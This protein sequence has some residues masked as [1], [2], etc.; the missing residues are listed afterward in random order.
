[1][2]E[3]DEKQL[4]QQIKSEDFSNAYFIYGEESYLK[5]YYVGRLKSKLIGKNFEDF[6]LH[7][8]NGKKIG[9]SDILKDADLLPM[10]GGYNLVLVCDYPFD[11]SSA[12]CGVIKEYLKDVP[13]TTVLLFWYDTVEVDIKKNS[14]WKSIQSAFAKAGSSVCF[15]K[16]SENELVKMLVNGCKRRNAALSPENAKYLISFSGSDI[17]TLLNET[18]KLCAFVGNGEI[19]LDIINK[20]AVKS[21]QAKV[22][23]LSKSIVNGDYE[24][25][26]SVLNSLFAA[27]EEPVSVLAVISNC[28]VDMYRVK[29]AKIAGLSFSDPAE[30]YN[31]RGREFA[32][33][34]AAKSSASLSVEQL[35]KSL[36]VLMQADN[37]LKSASADS[38]LVLEETMVK[39]LLISKEV[40]YD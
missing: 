24:K 12:D 20:L 39:L 22:F 21:L 38:R 31:Y 2:A 35:R 5:E 4:K 14:K 34:N 1:M 40:K 27:K 19:T 37:S 33:R 9:I 23:D 7:S 25:A 3:I 18:E 29:C 10:M 13:Q 28:F 11:K 8:Y 15:S 26:Y 17:K 30:Y 16:R 32:L 6:N 36:E